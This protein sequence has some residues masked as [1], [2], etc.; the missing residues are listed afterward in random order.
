[1]ITTLGES[2]AR[3][4]SQVVFLLDM[5]FLTEAGTVHSVAREAACALFSAGLL[6]DLVTSLTCSIKGWPARPAEML[7][8]LTAHVDQ[9]DVRSCF[10][11]LAAW[12]LS[13]A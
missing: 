12:Y 8:V 5:L 7:K 6:P 4:I 1:M 9:P 3:V 10:F 2:F 13:L 11:H